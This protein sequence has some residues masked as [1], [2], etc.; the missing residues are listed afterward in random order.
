MSEP[1]RTLPP[2]G[3]V[4]VVGAV[5]VGVALRFVTSSHLWLD[6]A[7]SVDIARLPIG[8][9][10]A[11]LRHD[12]H[13]PLYYLL[14]HGWMAVFGEGATAVRALS[15]ALAVAT[16]PLAWL[17]G[18]RVAGVAGGWWALGL[19]ALCPFLVRYGTET[20]M[21]ALVTLLV[22]A[23]W[24]L[25]RRALEQPNLAR[26]A[27]IA[28]VSGLLLLTHY[29]AL[30]LLGATVAVLA[31][32][33]RSDVPARRVLVAVAAGGVLLVPWLP[34]MLDQSAHTGTPWASPVRPTT[35]VTNSLADIGG[36]GF[37]EAVLLGYGLLALFAV[38]FAGRTTGERSIELDAAGVP[39]LRP[40]AAVIGLTLA[41]ATVVG[42]A[43]HTTFASRYVAALV[44]LFLLVAAV[45]AARLPGRTVPVVALV[46]VLA[47]GAVGSAHN[48]VTDRT[49]AGVIVDAIRAGAR[50]DDLVVVCPDQLGPS[51]HRLLPGDLQLLVYPTLGDGALVDWRDYEA[52]NQSADP[53]AFVAEIL[54]R[55]RAAG[56]QSIWVVA[57]GSYK[58]LEGQCEAVLSGLG[59]QSPGAQEIVTDD[60][61]AYFEHAS[62]TRFAAA[63][64]P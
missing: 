20:R 7:L 56:A 59:A 14:L 9:I 36:G 38:G 44:P 30:W 8:D 57:S 24:L 50:A 31:W 29:W 12:G 32:H 45:G 11:A 16:L 23:G 47:L 64:A 46:S 26:L 33:A 13:P 48:V 1:G 35:M 55:A 19:F 4:A 49:Q 61:D 3:K 27:P 58:T 5:V 52:R 15:G 34:A 63:P 10:P 42:Y 25:V 62:L 43:T 51:V 41:I 60:S 18:R 17:A 28:A 21:Y 39:G 6:E 40:E 54:M 22:L 37:A 53:A 2:I